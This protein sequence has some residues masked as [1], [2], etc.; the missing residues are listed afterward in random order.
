MN[1]YGNI[2]SLYITQLHHHGLVVPLV[3]KHLYTTQMY[4]TDP[5]LSLHHC[6]HNICV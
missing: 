1:Q 6:W 2:I 3:T 5:H 4:E